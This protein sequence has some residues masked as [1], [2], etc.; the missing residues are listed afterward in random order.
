L[1]E[2]KRVLLMTT[3]VA[4][5]TGA[6]A[7]EES[8]S[9]VPIKGHQPS[10][11]VVNLNAPQPM[12]TSG[13]ANPGPLAAQPAGFEGTGPNPAPS[14]ENPALVTGAPLP[15]PPGVEPGKPLPVYETLQQAA[16]A[17][18]DPLGELKLAGSSPSEEEPSEEIDIYSVD[19]WLSWIQNNQP[20]AI[21]VG[22]GILGV[23][24]AAWLFLRRLMSRAE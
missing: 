5:S 4:V 21:K 15:L 8:F 10:A 22:G 23:L 9:S 2:M 20:Q 7:Q 12:E 24:L 6:L 19:Y 17:G 18:V 13:A 14:Q 16:D 1:N 11:G 3:L